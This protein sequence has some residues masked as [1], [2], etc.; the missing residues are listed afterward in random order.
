VHTHTHKH[1]EVVVVDGASVFIIIPFL[2][3]PAVRST[4]HN[5]P[6][7]TLPSRLEQATIATIEMKGL[8]CLV[9]GIAE[10]VRAIGLAGFV[11]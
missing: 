4:T 8:V 3:F 1:T 9:S 2:I 10:S 5:R 11:G 7:H 6:S